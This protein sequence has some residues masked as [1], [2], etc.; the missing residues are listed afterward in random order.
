MDIDTGFEHGMPT[1]SEMLEHQP[2]LLIGEVDRLQIELTQAKTNINKLVEI[3]AD[4]QAQL[5]AKSKK[6]NLANVRIVMIDN[7]LRRNEGL[8]ISHCF[9]SQKA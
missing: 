9:A 8:D 4:L 2:H 3:N 7:R 5:S 1:R 6:E